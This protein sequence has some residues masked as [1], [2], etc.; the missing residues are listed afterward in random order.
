MAR[1]YGVDLASITPDRMPLG[2]DPRCGLHRRLGD[3]VRS[4]RRR[5]A[6]VELSEA[7]AHLRGQERSQAIEL[8]RNDVDVL[9]LYLEQ[10]GELV[11]E[12][13]ATLMGA[14][15]LQRRVLAG[16]FVAGAMVIGL[17]AAAAA[18]LQAAEHRGSSDPGAR[19]AELDWRD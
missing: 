19:R 17:S 9:A 18:N 16:M 15:Q 7:G 10:P 11:V 8:R 12:R 5:V 2:I 13:L 14:T 1:L 3:L 4:G 6:P